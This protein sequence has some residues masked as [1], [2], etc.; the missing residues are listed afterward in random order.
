MILGLTWHVSRCKAC[1]FVPKCIP[2]PKAAPPLTLALSLLRLVVQC[3]RCPQYAELRAVH[4]VFVVAV[5]V[6]VVGAKGCGM[7]LKWRCS[8]KFMV[9]FIA[10]DGCLA[11]R[12][13]VVGRSGNGHG[14]RM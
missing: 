13:G 5:A 11:V 3:V 7:I 8:G 1:S 4:C 12:P 14:K 6:S 10:S 9:A 2:D